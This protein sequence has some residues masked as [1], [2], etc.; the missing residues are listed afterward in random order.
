[1]KKV[2]LPLLMLSLTCVSMRAQEKEESTVKG[3]N[4]FKRSSI[5]FGGGFAKAANPMTEGYHMST[6]NFFNANLGFRYMFNT[7]FGLKLTGF[8]DK[9]KEDD[10]SLPFET[11]AYG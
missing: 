2:V 11:S 6:T 1:M 10:I 5:E 8:Y 7:K 9:F 3:A 4:D